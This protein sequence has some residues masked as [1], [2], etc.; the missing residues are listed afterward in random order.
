MKH[1][2]VATQS[3]RDIEKDIIGLLNES[4]IEIESFNAQTVGDA[5]VVIL[6]V[7][8]YDDALQLLN[9]SSLKAVG[10]DGLV[11]QLE[12]RPGELARIAKKLDDEACTVRSMRILQKGGGKF[13]VAIAVDN[14]SKAADVLDAERIFT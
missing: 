13:V 6:S 3:R 10:E 9:A 12:D 4:G 5:N 14:F 11:I 8:R 2:T 1:I 7:D